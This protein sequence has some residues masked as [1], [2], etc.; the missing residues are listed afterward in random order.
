MRE[1][2]LV[3]RQS[4]CDRSFG[5]YIVLLVSMSDLQFPPPRTLYTP[6]TESERTEPSERYRRR[7]RERERER[8]REPERVREEREIILEKRAT[9]PMARPSGNCLNLSCNPIL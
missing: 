8:A 4:N 6:R 7:E 2:E 1:R 9:V 3:K 5:Q